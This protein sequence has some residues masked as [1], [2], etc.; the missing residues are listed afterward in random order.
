MTTGPSWSR[1]SV[2]ASR[3]SAAVAAR[4]ARAPAAGNLD[5]VHLQVLALALGRLARRVAVTGEQ[6]HRRDNGT[7]V[8]ELPSAA[9]H[10]Q[11]VNRLVAVIL[12]NHDRDRQSPLEWRRPARSVPSGTRRLR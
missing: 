5:E 2:S 4:I 1:V 9:P 10:L 6:A 7:C 11:P 12:R 8:A 3:T